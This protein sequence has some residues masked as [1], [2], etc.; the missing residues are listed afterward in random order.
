M[1]LASWARDVLTPQDSVEG[2]ILKD[3]PLVDVLSQAPLIAHTNFLHHP[4][5][6]RVARQVGRVDPMQPKALEPICHH[7]VCCLGAI[8]C[9]PVG[10]PNPIA[11]FRMG[12][13]LVDTQT[14]GTYERVVR[15]PNDGEIGE[16][17]AL[18][19]RLVGANPLLRHAVCVWMWDIERRRGDLAVPG[20]TLDIWGI[21]D[22][23]RSEDQTGCFQC[24][25]LFHG[26]VLSGAPNVRPLL[27]RVWH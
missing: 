20:E 6:R 12:V 25:T 26:I 1:P 27:G 13:L 2:E 8:A 7:G 22:G 16:F 14:N 9:I 5:R 10:F 15:T 4:P 3:L 23:E 18:I 11:E 24:W 19:L 21:S 17:A